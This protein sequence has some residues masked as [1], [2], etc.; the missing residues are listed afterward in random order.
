MQ[1]QWAVSIVQAFLERLPADPGTKG[2][3]DQLAKACRM[4][5]EMAE[6]KS[7]RYCWINYR[8]DPL[9]AVTDQ[10]VSRCEPGFGQQEWPRVVGR[11]RQRRLRWERIQSRKP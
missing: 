9:Q 2:G 11:I 6:H 10:V 8:L 1:A 5:A 3:A 4:V 7:G